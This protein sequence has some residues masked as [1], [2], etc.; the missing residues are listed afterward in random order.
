MLPTEFIYQNY[1]LNQYVNDQYNK[2]C[3]SFLRAS[4]NDRLH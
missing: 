1:N 2:D 3:F 4:R